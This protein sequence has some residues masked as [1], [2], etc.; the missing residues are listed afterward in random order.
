MSAA[1]YERVR[2]YHQEHG[3]DVASETSRQARYQ[4]ILNLLDLDPYDIL[5]DVG[6]GAKR[7]RDHVECGYVGIDLLEGVNVMEW[8][9]P[10]EW[11]VANGLVYKLPS[12]VEALRLLDKCWSL[13]TRGFVFTSLDCWGHYHVEELTLDPADVL[14]WARKRADGVRL[15]A[16]YKAGD[17]AVGMYRP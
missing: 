16:S 17:F 5:L 8:D 12:E 10:A 4:A 3:D 14:Q 11:V 2:A 13:C 15:D 6:C 1:L 9:Q 7:F